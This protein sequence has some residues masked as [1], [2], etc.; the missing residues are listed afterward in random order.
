MTVHNYQ[1][2]LA[3]LESS[4]EFSRRGGWFHHA[5]KSVGMI[6][7]DDVGQVKWEYPLEFPKWQ[8]WK[9]WTNRQVFPAYPYLTDVPH[10]FDIWQL[11][12]CEIF[13]KIEYGLSESRLG[14]AM[15]VSTGTGTD[16][17]GNL[18]GSG[19][20]RTA[21]YRTIDETDK[22]RFCT[23]YTCY[24]QGY[25]GVAST[26]F[27]T[28]SKGGSTQPL[29]FMVALTLD[30]QNNVTARGHSLTFVN[31][32]DPDTTMFFVVSHKP[33]EVSIHEGS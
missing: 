13:V 10:H 6:Q 30:D 16:G 18:I 15:W 9:R 19:V 33:G 26:Y 3:R 23:F 29:C 25:L 5:L 8:F 1:E 32:G 17:H 12:R 20:P 7:T 31:D 11:P 21:V 2:H 28:N 22:H 24:N 14:L 27:S 4:K